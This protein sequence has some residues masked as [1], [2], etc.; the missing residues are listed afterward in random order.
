MFTFCTWCVLL[1]FYEILNILNHNTHNI[2][3]NNI[4][5]LN[6][7]TRKKIKHKD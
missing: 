7:I 5:I 3:Y 1:L 4:V 2:Y 6:K